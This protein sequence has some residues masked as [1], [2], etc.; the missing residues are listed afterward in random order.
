MKKYFKT[1]LIFSILFIFFPI[2][3]SLAGNVDLPWETTFDCPEW[4]ETKTADWPPNCA[5]IEIGVWATFFETQ[6]TSDANNPDGDGGRGMRFWKGDGSNKSSNVAKLSFGYQK[7]FWVRW[8]MRY[9]TGFA[10]DPYYYDKL[11]YLVHDSTGM[12]GLSAASIT[13]LALWS[14]NP[15]TAWKA[16]IGFQDI[17]GGG[18]STSDGS[19]HSIECYFKM[20]TDTTD[21]AVKLWVDGVLKI[22]ETGLNLSGGN[23]TIQSEGWS[24]FTFDSNQSTPANGRHV[25]VD[26]DDMAISNIGY[27]GPN[28]P[29]TPDEPKE[30][31]P[32][33]PLPPP[34]DLEIDSK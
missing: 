15:S 30:P 7:E 31:I 27:I 11:I 24:G 17:W 25:Y 1:I 13:K 34:L 29:S 12:G 14:N 21:G 26:W 4:Q 32:T 5:G 28:A 18:T 16:D 9:E 10:W 22:S 20:D 19:W 2:S 23:A 3:S 8:Y 6:I 33:L